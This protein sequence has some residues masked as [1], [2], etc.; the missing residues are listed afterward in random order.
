VSV[1]P[2]DLD[3]E[4]E[5]DLGG[6]WGS[7]V[8][9]WWL[10]LA[11]LV[12]GA[13]LG[14]LVSLSGGG[15]YSAQAVIYLGQP[16]SPNGG[17]Q[18]QSLA[19]NPSTV[20]TVVRSEANLRR[21]AHDVGL[22]IA[23]LRSGVSATPVAGA[24][25]KLGQTPLVAIAVSGS[26]PRKI[27]DAANRLADIAVAA[28]SQGYVQ[29]KVSTLQAEIATDEAELAT[30]NVRLQAYDAAAT[31]GTTTDRLVVLTQA[32]LAEQRRSTVEQ[33]LM[34]AR[35]LLSLATGVEVSRVVTRAAASKTTGRS[36]RNSVV[37]GAFVGLVLGLL[38]AL[39]WEPLARVARRTTA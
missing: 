36:S 7:I 25:A 14:Y 6:L 32:G 39:L 20:R 10:P 13:V 17:G 5:L 1:R 31:K 29:T 8:S 21:V 22:P 26:P 3:A 38:A 12:A 15:A 9:R 11:G 2:P 27:A 37:A 24:I 34:S 35:Q 33:D 23:K 28:V 19:T 4:Q 18:A 30:I 16:L